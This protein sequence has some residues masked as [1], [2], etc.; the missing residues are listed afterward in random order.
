MKTFK[1]SLTNP[2]GTGGI[3]TI[4]LKNR[5]YEMIKKDAGLT[6][7]LIFI[8]PNQN[9]ESIISLAKAK[10]PI[11][12]ERSIACLIRDYYNEVMPEKDKISLLDMIEKEPYRTVCLN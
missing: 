4:K 1:I 6:I 9:I 7:R 8:I 11:F 10:H 12:S 2:E 3:I 5:F